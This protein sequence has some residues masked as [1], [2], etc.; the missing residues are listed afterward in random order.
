M[1]PCV[2][3]HR[4]SYFLHYHRTCLN[5]RLVAGM[6]VDMRMEPIEADFR[7]KKQI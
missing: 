4:P 2:S 5:I 1:A 3:T 6:Y 7:S